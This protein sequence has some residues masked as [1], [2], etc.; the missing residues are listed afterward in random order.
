MRQISELLHSTVVD[1]DGAELGSVN[2]VRLVQDGPLLDG[3]GA[4]LRVDG[5]VVGAGS[6]A[7]RLGY[8][9]HGVAGPALLKTIFGAL[10]RRARFVPWEQ[11]EEWAGST[12]R[13]RCR[14][15]DVSTVSEVY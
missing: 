15:A 14:S 8:H 3:F 9:R 6:L 4:A 11:V 1:V 10:E 7:V 12:V 2:D 13:L 5:L